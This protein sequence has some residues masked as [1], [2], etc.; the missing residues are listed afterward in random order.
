MVAL[1]QR[2]RNTDGEAVSPDRI[3]NELTNLR[4]HVLQAR[5]NSD[6]QTEASLEALWRLRLQTLVEQNPALAR[7]LEILFREHL[8]R[9][10]DGTDRNRIETLVKQNVRVSGGTSYTSG[11]DMHIHQDKEAP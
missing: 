6:Q 8:L 10:A 9:D 4:T 2:A 3:S 11:R 1:W 5:S 7:E